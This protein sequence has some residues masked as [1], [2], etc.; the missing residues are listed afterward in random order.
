M[1]S[2]HGLKVGERPAFVLACVV[3]GQSGEHNACR[4]SAFVAHH[5]R[6]VGKAVDGCGL[7]LGAWPGLDGTSA[8]ADERQ[9]TCD[10]RSHHVDAVFERHVERA[11]QIEVGVGDVDRDARAS[12]RLRP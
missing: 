8:L 1:L 4:H 7:D 6:D 9:R 3:L 10:H 5:G 12:V 11:D 2:E